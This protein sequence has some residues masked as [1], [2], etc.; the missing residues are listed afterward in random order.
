MS[1]VALKVGSG[2]WQLHR[3]VDGG[4]RLDPVRV[5]KAL[6][7]PWHGSPSCPRLNTACLVLPRRWPINGDVRVSASPNL[8]AGISGWQSL[9]VSEIMLVSVQAL[10][11]FACS[12]SIQGDASVARCSSCCRFW[13][14]PRP[15]EC[16]GQGLTPCKPHGWLAVSFNVCSFS[17][18]SLNGFWRR[19]DQTAMPVPRCAMCAKGDDPANPAAVCFV[20]AFF[21]PRD[22]APQARPSPFADGRSSRNAK[23]QRILS[24][25]VFRAV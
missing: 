21:Q 8:H 17:S 9:K 2:F 25:V 16:K 12:G 11:A 20:R 1:R 14:A 5:P 13:A 4:Q 3:P 23:Q 6:A 7:F 19:H 15:S 24:R 18:G 10:C 22:L